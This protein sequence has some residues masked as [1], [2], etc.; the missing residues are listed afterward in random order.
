MN[1]LVEYEPKLSVVVPAYNEEATVAHVIEKLLAVPSLLEIIVVDDASTDRTSS[2]LEALRAA[3][4]KLRLLRHPQNRGKTAALKTG[5]AA[6]VGEIVIV[7]DADLEYDPSEIQSVIQPILDGVADVV[8]GSRFLIR[9][10]ARV[11][12]FYHYLANKTLTFFSNLLTNVN[13]S[14]VET[15]Y[16]AFRG[17]I[18]RDMI[19]TSSG[20]GFEIEVTAKICKLGC[21]CFEVPISY[22]GRTYHQ[23][24]KIGVTDGIAAFWYTVRYNLFTNLRD[25]FRTF[26]SRSSLEQHRE[27]WNSRPNRSEHE[28]ASRIS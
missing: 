2:V 26:H 24:K 16:K 10:A 13:F 12:Y 20:F 25:S 17:E 28:P 6:S 8:Y 9:K 22:Y 14:D 23:G 18:I 4:P 11:L 21:A 5:F 7:Q 19:I 1:S 3:T 15:G 27:R